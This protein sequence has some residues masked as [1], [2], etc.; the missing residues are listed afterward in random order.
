MIENDLCDAY[1]SKYEVASYVLG[2]PLAVSHIVNRKGPVRYDFIYCKSKVID[3][4]DVDYR[5][6]EAIKASGDHAFV[7]MKFELNDE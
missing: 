5:L 4:N 1:L 3:I 6:E 2:E 7:V